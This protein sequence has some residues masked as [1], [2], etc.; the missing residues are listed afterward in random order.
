M[1]VQS[2]GGFRNLVRSDIRL[3]FSFLISELIHM[4]FSM[5]ILEILEFKNKI[6]PNNGG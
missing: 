1:I 5:F 3:E 4:K 6:G 2:P